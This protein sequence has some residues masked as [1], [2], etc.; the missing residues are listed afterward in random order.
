MGSATAPS[1]GQTLESPRRSRRL[2]ARRA[3]CSTSGPALAPSRDDSLDAAMA[4]ITVHHWNDLEAGLAEMVRV[5]R[6]RV[7]VLTFTP[8]LPEEHWMRHDYF[9]RYSTSTPA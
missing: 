3:A 9:Q 1:A 8:V 4:L 2:W 6:Q 5:A 7:V